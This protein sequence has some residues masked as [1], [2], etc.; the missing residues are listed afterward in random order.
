MKSS[1]RKVSGVYLS[2][3]LSGCFYATFMQYC[4]IKGWVLTWEYMIYCL[5]W[6]KI[7]PLVSQKL[8]WFLTIRNFF[9]W[10]MLLFGSGLPNWVWEETHSSHSSVVMQRSQRGNSHYVVECV[11]L[12]LCGCEVCLESR[13]WRQDPPS[14]DTS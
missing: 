6:W 8:E 13:D 14:S 11:K 12:F 10:Q 3:L 1:F 4:K 9:L 2:I 7:F 5:V